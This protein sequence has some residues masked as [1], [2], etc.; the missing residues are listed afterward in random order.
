MKKRYLILED[1]T[2]FEGVSFGS[3]ATKTGELII[4]SNINGYQETITNPIYHNQIVA[5]SQSSIG[6]I[7]INRKNYESIFSSI[8]GVVV[9]EYTDISINHLKNLSLDTFLIQREI[10]G[11]Q[12]IDTRQLMKHINKNG[13]MKASIVDVNDEH[14]FN[15]LNAT[16]LNNQ[17][18][19]SVAINKPYL[20]PGSGKTI[21]VLDFGLKEGILRQLSK[22]NCN[23]VVLP[24]NTNFQD[25]I[26][27]DPEG[28]VLSTGPGD[29][30]E[31]DEE[32]LKTIKLIQ[33]KIP[34]FAMG[35]GHELFALANGAKI[36]KLGIGHHGSNHPIKKII[37]NQIIYAN[38]SQDYAVESDSI[39][40]KNLITTY[41]DLINGT[42]QGLRHREFPAFTVQFSP[43]GAAGPNDSADIFDE[44]LE[45]IN[46]KRGQ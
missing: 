28:I 30:L 5:F 36:I 42:V 15:Q 34:L 23:I 37:T 25:I 14:A 41:V 29:P 4:T 3:D 9:N 31:V 22:R 24:W 38:Q 39:N 26:N 2:S 43:D 10:P 35:L 16:V 44:F 32:I 12:G 18:I 13:V 17:Q 46:S 20:I 8:Q 33:T 45:S 19:Q 27:L 40:F 7:G 11:I 21:I 1:G 6:N